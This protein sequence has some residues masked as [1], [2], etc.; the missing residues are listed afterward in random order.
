VRS[1]SRSRPRDRAREPWKDDAAGVPAAL[2]LHLINEDQ[3][4]GA[5]NV[6][7]YLNTSLRA[8]GLRSVIVALEPSGYDRRGDVDLVL[9]GRAWPLSRSWWRL[10]TLLK[11]ERPTA[12]LAHGFSSAAAAWCASWALGRRRPRLVWQRILRLPGQ[13]GH[14]R[15]ALH[16]MVA[17][18]C[19]AVVCITTYLCDET[20]RLGFRG[21]PMLIP[22]HRP[23]AMAADSVRVE[24]AVPC[25]LFAG[26]L[27]DQKNP[28]GFLDLAELVAMER[29]TAQFVIAG[30]GPLERQVAERVA[31]SPLLRSRVHLAGHVDDV[32]LLLSNASCLVLTSSNESS[33]GI[34]IEAMMAGCP[35]AAFSVDGIEELIGDCGGGVVPQGDVGSLARLVIAEIDDDRPGQK[36]ARIKERGRMFST[37]ATLPQY[38]EALGVREL[39]NGR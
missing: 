15:Y 22:N 5:E 18:R 33:P 38:L 19:D 25:V 31:R 23:L 26:R 7:G 27:V 11:D 32:A 21:V 8:A 2:I 28:D 39:A 6:A 12:V 17:R 1:R 36:R 20:H 10:R 29:S 14:V 3:H 16:R 9:G 13:P 34:V 24:R 37:E 35:V 4:R 30:A